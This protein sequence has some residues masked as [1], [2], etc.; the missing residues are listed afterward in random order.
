MAAAVSFFG[1]LL[2][3]RTSPVRMAN[4]G[5]VPFAFAGIFSLGLCCAPNLRSL[6]GSAW[7]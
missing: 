1:L 5:F 3:I 6:E 7:W 2:Y 4:F